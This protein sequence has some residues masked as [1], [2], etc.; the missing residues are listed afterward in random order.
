[1]V[2]DPK[3]LGEYVVELNVTD[4][5]GAKNL[6]AARASNFAAPAQKQMVE[7]FWDNTNTDMDL[8]F[9]NSPGAPVGVAPDD[10]F[11][12]NRTPDWGVPGD[13]T[14]NPEMTQDALRGFGPEV[15][16]YVNP[17][18]ATYRVAVEFRNLHGAND[19]TSRVTVRIYEFGVVKGE[20]TKT[21]DQEAELWTVADIEWPSGRI[22]PVNP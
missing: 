1:M 9:L 22:T 5:Q 12:Q 13:S 21:L 8:H 17:I 11:Y 18:S 19:P 14:D 16:G 15:V 10:C 6:V 4:A 3:L 2:L 20:F 7:M